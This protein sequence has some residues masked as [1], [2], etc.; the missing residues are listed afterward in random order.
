[1]IE[2][3]RLGYKKKESPYLNKVNRIFRSGYYTS[4]ADVLF[5]KGSWENN[6]MPLYVFL[7]ISDKYGKMPNRTYEI[8][9]NEV[10]EVS[11][12]RKFS[13]VFYEKFLGYLTKGYEKY[14]HKEFRNLRELNA[15][16]TEKEINESVEYISKAIAINR[17]E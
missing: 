17:Y 12:S 15:S 4:Y 10:M 16:L 13:N 9:F 5:M 14:S 7:C 1:M 3:K 11:S 8:G 6:P 2:L